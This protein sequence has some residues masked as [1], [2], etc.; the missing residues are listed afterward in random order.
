[1]PRHS[2]WERIGRPGSSRERIGR[3][4]SDLTASLRDL[5]PRDILSHVSRYTW[6]QIENV[7]PTVLV[8]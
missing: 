4:G 6:P 5:L 7:T 2:A 3:P 1:L 8:A